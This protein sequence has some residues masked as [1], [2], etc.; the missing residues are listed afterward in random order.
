MAIGRKDV[1][2]DK[3]KSPHK[4]GFLSMFFY[5]YDLRH[6]EIRAFILR[7]SSSSSSSFLSS[8]QQLFSQFFYHLCTMAYI[9][10]HRSVSNNRNHY[11]LLFSLTPNLCLRSQVRGAPIMT[12]SYTLLLKGII[13]F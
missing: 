2:G 10:C 3:S 5:L 13:V 4:E 7:D 11:H 8:L 6:T 9:P 12:Y 1:F